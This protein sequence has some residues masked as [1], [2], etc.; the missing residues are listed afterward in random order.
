VLPR[1]QEVDIADEAPVV[2]LLIQRKN[3][4]TSVC[5]AIRGLQPDVLAVLYFSYEVGYSV[6]QAIGIFGWV[7][8]DG[9]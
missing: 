1:R 6:G 4:A 2:P 9:V 3:H 8:D 7:H 5:H